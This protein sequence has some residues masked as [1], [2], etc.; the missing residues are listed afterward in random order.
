MD[1][2]LVFQKVVV[3]FLL[4]MV[5]YVVVKKGLV[6]PEGQ[7]SVTNLLLYVFLPCTLL[8]T[9][10]AP[11]VAASFFN[12]L[13]ITFT[14]AAIYL[15]TTLLSFPIARALTKDE[16][17]VAILVVGMVLPNVAFMGYPIIEAIIGQEYI[18]YAVMGTI[19]FE[20]ISWSLMAS[21]IIKS[22]GV[23]SNETLFQRLSRTPAIIAIVISLAI[24]VSPFRIPEPFISTIHLLANAMS[25]VAMI[26]VGMA[27]AKADIKKSLV[28]KRTLR[29]I[30]R[31][32]AR[33]SA[34]LARIVQ[35][36]RV[37][38]RDLLYAADS[39]FDA[40]RWLHEHRRRTLWRRCNLRLRNRHDVYIVVADHDSAFLGTNLG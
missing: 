8:R 28:S 15:T 24:Y 7:K 27:L 21:I 35:T 30:C 17:K 6:T 19:A 13:Q 40:I 1:F 4:I 9:F 32:F 31:S 10:Q 36:D 14:M 12:G 38:R 26:I 2:F 5:G 3:I 11:F 39:D 18:F 20:V 33:L 37:A 23:E 34:A 16:K 25:P 22:T 29:R